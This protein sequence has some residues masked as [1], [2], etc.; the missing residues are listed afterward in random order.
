MEK[1]D[2]N[3]KWFDTIQVETFVGHMEQNTS[4]MIGERKP[5]IVLHQCGDDKEALIGQLQTVISGIERDFEGF[6]S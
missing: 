5:I 2:N 6:A 4:E 3:F 1:K